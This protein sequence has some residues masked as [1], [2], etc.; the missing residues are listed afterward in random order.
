[1]VAELLLAQ[2]ESLERRTIA[3]SQRFEDRSADRVGRG[4]RVGKRRDAIAGC[5]GRAER[6]RKRQG[7]TSSI[8]DVF[9][10]Q[11]AGGPG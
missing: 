10:V 8:H 5:G 11:E 4:E 9:S 7:E 3:G 6:Q 2:C 1:M